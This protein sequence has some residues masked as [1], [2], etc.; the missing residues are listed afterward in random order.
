MVKHARY[1]WLLLA[2]AHLTQRVFAAILQRIWGPYR[3]D[4][5]GRQGRIRW[6]EGE[7]DGKV[8]EKSLAKSPCGLF[9][10]RE[11]ADLA[12]SQWC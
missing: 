4:R 6:K 5:T 1:Y 9:S 8:S 7:W 3:L 2:E 12:P 10:Y 11:E